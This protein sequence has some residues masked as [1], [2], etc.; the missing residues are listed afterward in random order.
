MRVIG[1]TGSIA[2]GKSTVSNA[3]IRKGFPVIDGDQI[4]RQITAAGGVAVNDIRSAFGDEYILPDG[5]MNRRAMGKL[6][7]SD[8][9]AREKLDRV[10]APYLRAATTKCIEHLRAQDTK[11]CFLDMPLLFEK[12]YDRYCDSIWCVWLPEDIQLQRLVARDGYSAEEALARM[13]SVMSSDEKANLSTVIIDNSRS[14]EETLRY[15]DELLRREVNRMESVPRRRRTTDSVSVTNAPAV[16]T[17]FQQETAV[18]QR[19]DSFRKKAPSRKSSWTLPGYMKSILIGLIVIL[20]LSLTAQIWMNAYLTRC[21]EKHISEQRA[22]D[23]QYPLQY[24]DTI[25]SI[26][27][28]YN[29]SPSLVAAVI[30]NESSFRPSVESSV[31]ARGLMQLMPDTADWIAKKL[32]IDNYQFEMLNDPVTNIRFGCWYLSYLSSQFNGN[33][34]CVVCAYHAG[35][36]EIKGWLSNPIYSTDGLTLN[37]DKLPDEWATK[38][39]AGRVTRDYGIY[40]AKYFQQDLLSDS[41]DTASVHN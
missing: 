24:R 28:E 12:G 41:A 9:L 18:V 5:S 30:R 34:Y 6:V 29:L 21:R 13:R 16:P 39:Y 35:Q 2:C 26:A 23:E 11:L 32:K 10:L 27:G 8:P 14:K 15:V 40:Q 4:A 33:P 20:C 1:I 7:F 36:G 22:I 19:P 31:G 25:V 37:P 3:L 17:A 38:Q